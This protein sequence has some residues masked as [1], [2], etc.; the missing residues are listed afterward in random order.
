M[1]QMGAVVALVGRLV[2]I[3][4][5][6]SHLGIQMG[7]DDRQRIRALATSIGSIRSDLHSGRAPGAIELNDPSEAL[8]GGV[9]LL[10]MEKTV[11]LIPV[12]FSSAGSMSELGFSPSDDK[13][14]ST[15]LAPDAFSNLDHLK[16]GLK[17]GL[18]ASLCSIIY[19][20]I[21]WPGISTAVTTCL[22]T[23]LSTVGSLARSRRCDSRARSWVTFFSGWVLKLLFFLI[24]TRLLNSQFYSS[25]LAL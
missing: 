9:P 3:A 17:G 18:A 24:S 1:E 13:R 23:A 16:F 2:D 21:A 10:Q 19:N 4:A 6:L 7:G 14:L 15:F 11:L 20:A 12:A 8:G 22:L 25:P 5:S